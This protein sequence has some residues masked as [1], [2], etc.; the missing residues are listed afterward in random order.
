[1]IRFL[2]AALVLATL[3]LTAACAGP[4][5]GDNDPVS[6]DGAPP[7]A[8]DIHGIDVARFQNSIDWSAVR[9]SGIEF[10]FIKATEGGDR[11]DPMFATN[12]PAARN[13]GVLR[14]A[15]HFYYF[16]TPPEVQA[17]WFIRN[18]PNE[19]GALPPVLDLEWN[20]YS[21]TCTTRPPGAEV[22]RQAQVFMDIVE[23]HYGQRPIIYTTLEFYRQTGIGQLN[24]EFWL[25]STA[26][27]LDT[28]YP[29][30]SWR[31]WQYTGT[32]VVPGVKGGVD[33]NVFA[34]NRATWQR[35]L[36]ARTR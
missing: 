25:R 15:Y 1:M 31:F 35:W 6:W 19:G 18:V 20:P 29:G 13:A 7:W 34:G 12:W 32:G 14:G 3:T 2:A 24:E 11:L 21:P 8:Y 4:Q 26:R 30:Q 28:T 9:Q 17:R 5:F 16:C 36:R 10:A 33:I 23:R 27:T 22:R